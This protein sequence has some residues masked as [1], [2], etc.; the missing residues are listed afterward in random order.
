MI[1]KEKMNYITLTKPLTVWIP[2]YEV[3]LTFL[4]RKLGDKLDI[5]P[6]IILLMIHD[7]KSV[8]DIAIVTQLSSE[9]IQ[10]EIERMKISGL[11]QSEYGLI[12][13]E[14]GKRILEIYQMAEQLSSEQQN[15]YV[16][17][18]NQK[19]HMYK[20]SDVVSEKIPIENINIKVKNDNIAKGDAEIFGDTSSVV[21]QLLNIRDSSL[22]SDEFTYQT[23][24]GKKKYLQQQIIRMPIFDLNDFPNEFSNL[25][26]PIQCKIACHR[27]EI[28][29]GEKK[30]TFYVDPV[31]KK[32]QINNIPKQS[33]S[34]KKSVLCF[35]NLLTPLQEL[36]IVREALQMI[37]SQENQDPLLRNL[38]RYPDVLCGY[39]E[40]KKLFK[41]DKNEI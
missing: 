11:L 17:A 4:I 39:A 33:L 31:R 22:T 19:M 34:S 27:Y 10:K 1:K 29:L 3:T 23:H 18:M 15:F 7:H 32:F 36:A 30:R 26:E 41:G 28:L 6:L 9:I 20:E 5:L 14:P 40:R 38:R 13:S 25:K 24:I 16:D 21:Q 12:V 8:D 35:K 2:I 37:G